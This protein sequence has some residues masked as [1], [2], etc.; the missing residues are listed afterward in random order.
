MRDAGKERILT[1]GVQERGDWG[2]EKFRT[3]WIK[4][5]RDAEKENLGQ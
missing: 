5:M 4:E 1:R 3:G 2:L